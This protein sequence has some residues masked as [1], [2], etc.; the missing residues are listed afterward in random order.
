MAVERQDWKGFPVVEGVRWFNLAVLVFTPLVAFY[1]ILSV[2]LNGKTLV[3]SIAYYFFAELQQDIIAYGHIGLT[4]RPFLC[5]HFLFWVA[6]VL[7]RVLVIGGH[8][9]IALTT[10]GETDT[11]KDPYDSTRGLAWSH[12]GWILFKTKLRSGPVDISDLANDPL[13]KW[14]HRYYFPL[15][16]IFGYIMPALIPVLWNDF[17]GGLCFSTAFRMTVAHHVSSPRVAYARLLKMVTYRGGLADP[18]VY[19]MM[20]F[21][22]QRFP[23]HFIDGAISDFLPRA[24]K[25]EFLAEAIGGV[26][27][28]ASFTLVPDAGHLVVQTHPTAL[29]KVLLHVLTKQRDNLLQAKL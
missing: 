18:T 3:F 21:T 13:V 26:Q 22:V 28:L 14:S 10:D 17:W 25:D 20:K 15:A 12:I 16:G 19:S 8:D 27:N 6:R 9:L 23:T 29:A 7:S 2:P 11:D 4:T 24:V 5:S 1:G